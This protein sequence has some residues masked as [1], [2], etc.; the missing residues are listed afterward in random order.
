MIR[1]G[2]VRRSA[3]S[4][5]AGIPARDAIRVASSSSGRWPGVIKSLGQAQDPRAGNAPLA[6]AGS[7]PARNSDDLPDPDGPST[8][9]VRLGHLLTGPGNQLSRQ[10]LAAEVPGRRPPA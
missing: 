7:N 8:I 5:P 2:S 6:T 4:A 1:A 3:S 10:L 9:E